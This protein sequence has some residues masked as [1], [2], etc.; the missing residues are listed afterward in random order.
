[1]AHNPNTRLLL[2]FEGG[3]V[4]D[5]SSVGSTFSVSTD[6]AVSTTLPKFGSFC[7]LDSDI[8]S[9]PITVLSPESVF[10]SDTSSKTFDIW[11]TVDSALSGSLSYLVAIEFDD[12]TR[13]TIYAGSAGVYCTA[14]GVSGVKTTILPTVESPYDGEWH[15]LR[16]YL[17]GSTC[18]VGFDGSTADSFIDGST[19][20]FAWWPVGATVTNIYIGAVMSGGAQNHLGK[21]DAVQFLEDD[22]SWDGTDWTVAST[23]PEDWVVL[24]ATGTGQNTLEPITS[25]TPVLGIL[26]GDGANTLTDFISVGEGVSPLSEIQGVGV[27][28]LP[29]FTSSGTGT[30]PSLGVGFAVL[31]TFIGDGVGELT[32]ITIGA[33]ESTAEVTSSGSGTVETV[34]YGTGRSVVYVSS[35]GYGS[36]L[37]PDIQGSGVTS[38]EWCTGSG[39]GKT[40]V[41]GV[42]YGEVSVTTAGY[43]DVFNALYGVGI[44]TTAVS[45]YAQ[46]NAPCYAYGTGTVN[47]IVSQGLGNSQ[48]LNFSGFG[49]S[50]VDIRSVG[51]GG[52]V[53]A[54]MGENS[55][56]VKTRNPDSFYYAFT[57][58]SI[59]TVEKQ[60]FVHTQ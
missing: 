6:G 41:S 35:Y 39:L 18:N 28:Q 37:P 25:E 47:D 3:V 23:P 14:D 21:L 52:T 20:P 9:A 50:A 26:T 56:S 53:C 32:P 22:S 58:H 30:I 60:I 40:R 33:G 38:T 5:T 8:T 7:F 10:A 24:T 19:D 12:Y 59:R 11:F 44:N 51:Y 29:S 57:F 49:D 2:N 36:N 54:G 13:L 45:S 1:M 43:G 16:V 4:A 31:A 46:G 27:C 17:S 15:N 34:F 42:G 48:P 55:T